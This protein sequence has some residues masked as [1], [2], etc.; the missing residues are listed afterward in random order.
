MQLRTWQLP[1]QADGQTRV[2][3]DT[4]ENLGLKSMRQAHESR[5]AAASVSSYIVTQNNN[6]V[7]NNTIHGWFS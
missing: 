4:S 6:I 1:R 5:R 7:S 2:G 3:K